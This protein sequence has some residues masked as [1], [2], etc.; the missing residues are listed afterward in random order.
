MDNEHDLNV[1]NDTPR[2]DARSSCCGKGCAAAAPADDPLVDFM[3][4]S[5]HVD[6]NEWAGMWGLN[7]EDAAC[8]LQSEVADKNHRFIPSLC[9]QIIFLMSTLPKGVR[10]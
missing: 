7:R 10:K 1:Y 6:F 2:N 3:S 8:S 4:Q 5:K 9:T